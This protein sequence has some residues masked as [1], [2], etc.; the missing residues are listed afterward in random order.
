MNI[1][2][3]KKD[4]DTPCIGICSTTTGDKVC[5]GCGRSLEEIRQWV[6]LDRAERVA[7]NLIAKKRMGK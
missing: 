4:W 5:R 7:V 1:S 6:S 2:G 3:T